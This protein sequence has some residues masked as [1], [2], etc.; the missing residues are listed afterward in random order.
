MEKQE[1]Q[2]IITKVG[3][4]RLTKFLGLIEKL[5]QYEKLAPAR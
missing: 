1:N 4:E 2:L 3:S 5:A